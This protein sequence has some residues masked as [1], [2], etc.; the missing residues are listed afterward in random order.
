[1]PLRSGLVLGGQPPPVTQYLGPVTLGCAK[2]LPRGQ[3][4]LGKRSNSTRH[5]PSL[6]HFKPSGQNTRVS[7]A[8]TLAHRHTKSNP[9]CD[10]RFIK[11]P[12]MRAWHSSLSLE[13]DHK[14]SQWQGGSV[15]DWAQ[16][17]AG[18]HPRH[19][20]YAGDFVQQQMLVTVHIGHHHLELIVRL[21][22]RDEQAFQHFGNG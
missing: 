5:S 15:D 2:W 17:K 11:A 12:V 10:A 1:M 14:P 18:M 4:G 9:S 7:A 19:P 8:A 21:L 3:R 16:H 6:D 20:S 22:A 13:A